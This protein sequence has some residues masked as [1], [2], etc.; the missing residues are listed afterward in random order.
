MKSKG[1]D[2]GFSLVELLV[3][4]IVIGILAAIALPSYLGAQNSARDSA[5]RSD[6]VHAKSALTAYAAQTDGASPTS[7]SGGVTN[8]SV[9]LKKLGWTQ[10]GNT[11][12][13]TYTKSG[14]SSG[15]CVLATSSTDARYFVTAGGTIGGGSSSTTCPASY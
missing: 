4:V 2:D 1:P 6:L 11:R 3:V 10:G 9:D 8:D 7:V 14:T 12:S 13:L 15:W 5:V